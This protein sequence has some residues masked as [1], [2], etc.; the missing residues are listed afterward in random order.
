MELTPIFVETEYVLARLHQ[1]N[2]LVVDLSNQDHFNRAHIP[3]AIHIDYALLI[4]GRK[5][6]P[7]QVPDQTQLERLANAL[8]V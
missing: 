3:G 8:G 6:A 5:P 4:D 7:G 2:A 1:K